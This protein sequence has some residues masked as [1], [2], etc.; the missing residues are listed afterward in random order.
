[1]AESVVGSNVRIAALEKKRVE[2][3]DP[4]AAGNGTPWEDRGSSGIAGAFFK[5]CWMS[6]VS[7]ATLL[8][9][10]RRPET[11][12]DATAFAIGCGI[13]WGFSWLIHGALFAE[14]AKTKY[15]AEVDP[16]IYYLGSALQVVVAPIA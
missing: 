10:I 14:Y 11:T 7:P 3:L 12:S 1:M 13:L 16:Q 8:R 4:M 9:D 6:L 5:T 15:Q 2:H